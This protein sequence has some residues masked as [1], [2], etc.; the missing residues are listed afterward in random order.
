MLPARGNKG[1]WGYVE[2]PGHAAGTFPFQRMNTRVL[3]AR[4]VRSWN[5]RV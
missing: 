2:G 1:P 4:S 5:C 3:R